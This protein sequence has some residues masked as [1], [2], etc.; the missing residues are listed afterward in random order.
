MVTM[1]SRP[2]FLLKLLRPEFSAF[3]SKTDENEI[4]DLIVID[5]QDK[6]KLY[7]RFLAT[8]LG[9]Y[10]HDG[11]GAT[12]GRLQTI[13][14]SNMGEPDDGGQR[15]TNSSRWL[16]TKLVTMMLPTCLP[17]SYRPPQHQQLQAPIYRPEATYV[18]GAGAIQFGN[19][20]E[21]YESGISMETGLLGAGC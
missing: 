6:P 2:V 11:Q 1:S 12:V 7:T 3:L 4:V 16:K 5:D 9:K 15:D 18:T 10:R 13:P 14:P 21:Y 20:L 17:A 8:P 19:D